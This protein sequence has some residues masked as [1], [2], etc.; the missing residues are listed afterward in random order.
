MHGQKYMPMLLGRVLDGE[1]DP[2]LVFI[3]RLPL[4]E[5]KQGFEI[6]KHKTDNCVKV[7]IKP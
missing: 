5:T 1:V 7:L 2:S 4:E 3:H 6:F